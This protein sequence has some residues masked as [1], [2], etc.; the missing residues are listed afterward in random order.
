MQVE[1]S[2]TKMPRDAWLVARWSQPIFGFR[3]FPGDKII[4]FLVLERREREE[5]GYDSVCRI[6]RCCCSGQDGGQVSMEFAR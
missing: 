5:G 1:S 3:E 2:T 4:Y 6:I